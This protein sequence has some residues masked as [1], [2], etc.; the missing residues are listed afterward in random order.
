MTVT[1]YDFND[2]KYASVH[3]LFMQGDTQEQFHSISGQERQ[4]ILL[5]SDVGL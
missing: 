2:E 1:V 5:R 3:W 4:I